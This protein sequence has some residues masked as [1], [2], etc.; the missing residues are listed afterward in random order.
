[1]KANL[2]VLECLTTKDGTISLHKFK[3]ISNLGI[4]VTCLRKLMS[5]FKPGVIECI[6]DFGGRLWNGLDST[7][8]G[9]NSPSIV[10]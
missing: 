9:G 1:M 5:V 4:V 3:S 6:C 8:V 7:S 10:E 2:E